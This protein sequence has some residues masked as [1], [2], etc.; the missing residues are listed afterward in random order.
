MEIKVCCLLRIGMKSH[1]IGTLLF[2]EERSVESQRYRLRKKLGLA[3]D[4]GTLQQALAKI[5]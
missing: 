2:I 1:E 4:N 5:A 3:G